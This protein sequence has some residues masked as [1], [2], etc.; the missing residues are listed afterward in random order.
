M[1]D[2][3]DR[4]RLAG[5][6]PYVRG[7]AALLLL[8]GALVALFLRTPWVWALAVA[9]TAFVASLV[10]YD[11]GAAARP[12]EL[13]ARRELPP[14][15]SMGVPN[16][17]DLTVLNTGARQ[18]R[19]TVRETPPV[20]FGGDR[21]VGDIDLRPRSERTVRLH[22]VPPGRGRFT[23][24][25]VAVRSLGPLGLAGRQGEV[26]E[27][28]EVRVYPDITAVHKYALLA[29]KG[30]LFELGVRNLRHRGQGTEFESLREYVPGDTFRDVDWKATAR[31]G[32][33]VTRTY[34]VERSQTMVLAVDAGRL[35]TPMVGGMSKLDR[36]VNASLLLA[37]LGL[38][39]E[40]QVGLLVFGRDI[41]AYLPP[42]KGRRQFGSI[43]E[44]LYAVEGRVEE[45]DYP[46][47]LRYLASKLGKRALVVLFTEL[48]GTD[49]SRRLLGV[50]D[51][52]T[53]RHLPLV[54][55]Q[56]NRYL[57]ALAS[58]APA[59][60]VDAFRSAVSEGVLREKAA[61]LR[62]LTVQ[63][64][65]ALDV[66]PEELSVSAVNRY[67]EIKARGAL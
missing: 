1:S 19:L 8:G 58:E 54:M 41:Q 32:R 29:R 35:M 67:L 60:E 51:T 44:A 38:E 33:P 3:P 43:L 37:Y 17:L 30:A 14:K 21:L 11:I 47:A 40:D 55:T 65:L 36:A 63:G 22:V 31:K 5:R 6:L 56:R 25:R 50:L 20:G 2:G 61:A 15:P 64:S 66:F 39:A 53:P 4:G 13:R 46:S 48:A 42:R 23:F 10:V 24:G 12:E 18:A 49:T 45:P 26:G 16:P 34:E 59:R 57:E 28:Y 62:T 27:P 7:R 9:W 52:L